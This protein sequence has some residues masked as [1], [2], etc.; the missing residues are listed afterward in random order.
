[1]PG[2]VALLDSHTI[3]Q[4]AAGEVVERP[5]SVV[6]EL[7]E[8]ALDAG[9]TRIEVT[10][11]EAG[12]SLIRVCDNGCGMGPED[13]EA[14]LLRHATS[15]IRSAGDL[16]RVATLGFRGEALPSIA[17][18]SRLG[19]ST[20]EDGAERT[21]L[22]FDFGTLKERRA[23]AG[24]QGT[25]VTVRDLFGNTPARLKFLKSD[26][27][28]TSA[29]AEL[30][31]RYAVAHP[32]VA[33]ILRFGEKAGLSTPGTGD[34]LE[35]L[36]GVWGA[37]LARA[38][39][40]VDSTVSGIRV[41]GFVGPPHLNRPNRN[42]QLLFVNGRPVR[43]KTLFA[44]VDAAFRSLTPERRYAV[45][46]LCLSVNP[47]DVD[48]NV[49][50][51]KSEVKFQREGTAFDAVRLAVRSSLMEHGLMPSA[52]T[53]ATPPETPHGMASAA[54]AL[55]T[56]AP[57][58]T[59]AELFVA[60]S[61]LQPRQE[62][63]PF[64]ELLDD[65][66]VMGQAVN[67]FIV[68]STR[69]GIVII[70]QHVAHERVLYEYLCGLKAGGAV[71]AQSLLS[72][73][74]VQFDRSAAIA[75][76]ERLEDLKGVG[77]TLEPFGQQD[78]LIRTVPAAA[79]NKDYKSLLREVADELLETGG[80]EKAQDIREKIWIMSACR[81]AVKAGDPLSVQEMERLIR[82]LAETENPYLCPHGRPITVT[83]TYD[84]LMRRFKR[85]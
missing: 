31:G 32:H 59:V 63:F 73:E 69:K 80:R 2:R 46:A 75:L 35:A 37:D 4:I 22:E 15:K 38:L 34:L 20:G 19:L 25:D 64:L 5:A 57:A 70:D 36:A 76:T 23:T 49:S 78:F 50:P 55:A 47:A 6:K 83:L 1:M 84:E 48:V 39:A 40:E 14:A 52:A 13:A 58:E 60:P 82:D 18:V 56:L 71:E 42:H 85:T 62:R 16:R 74:T 41:Q 81:M 45:V 30:T 12:R 44:A 79:A 65:L 61:E 72:P 43:S 33:F 68:A 67:T 51:T 7:I 3:N 27:S 77:F 26:T 17:S 54:A 11:E 24:P 8:N 9:A 10:L 21:A 66:R 29:V 53:G 28:E